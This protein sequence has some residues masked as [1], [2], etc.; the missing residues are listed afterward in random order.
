M[1]NDS[2]S[3]LFT[4]IRNAQRVGHRSVAV[5]ASKMSKAVLDVL[6]SEGFIE[7]YSLKSAANVAA[8]HYDVVL[9]YYPDGAPAVGRLDR[10]SRPGRRVYSPVKNLSRT[11]CGLGVSIL[12]TSQG[13]MSDIEARK[14][15]IGGEV[16]ARIS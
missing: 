14:K 15:N 7:A 3:D 5:V 12:S 16:L 9:R 11:S 8:K 4:R 1:I 10:V 6:K 13:I 2:V